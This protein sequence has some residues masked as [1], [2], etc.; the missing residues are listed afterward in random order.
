MNL[1]ILTAILGAIPQGIFIAGADRK[2]I[3]A[4]RALTVLTGYPEG[5]LIGRDCR[6]LHGHAT[7]AEQASHLD[8]AME[9][10]VAWAGELIN[11]TRAG[12]AFW[13]DLTMVPLCDDAGAITHHIGIHR[14][15]SERRAQTEE[16][17]RQERLYAYVFEHI[18]AGI[19]LHKADT[20]IMYANAMASTLLGVSKDQILGIVDTDPRWGFIGEDGDRLPV[21]AYPVNVAMRT[22][23]LVT[24]LLLGL[25]RTT[26]DKLVW[27]M[28][29]A[30]PSLNASGEPVEVVVSFTDVTELKVAEQALKKSEERLSLVLRGAN[31]AAWDWD[32]INNELY[33][34]P[35]WW[36]MIGYAEGEIGADSHLWRTLTHPDD[37]AAVAATFDPALANGAASYEVEFRL[38]HKQ[39]H[40]VTVLSRGFI[41]RD[42]AGKAI[43]VSGTN[44][45]LT[46]QKNA[47]RRIYE[48]AFFDPLTE[49][50]NRRLLNQLLDK[51]LQNSV[52][53]RQQGALL[54]IDLD[55]FKVLNDT[56]GHETGDMLLQQVGERLREA[57][58][59][60]D[61][62]ARLGGDEFLVILENMG[63]TAQ[64]CAVNARHQACKLQARLRQPY[65][66]GEIDYV[67]SASI[68]IAVFDGDGNSC[69]NILKQAD[70]AMYRAKS[71]GRDTLRF[72]D[73]SMQVAADERLNL[74][75][76]LRSYLRDELF[77]L[78]YQP[79]IDAGGSI[80]GAEVLARWFHAQ[81]GPISPVVF[82]P[83][84]ESSGIILALGEWI[85]ERACTQLCHWAARAGT[86]GL[87]LSVNVS[88]RQFTAPDFVA[89][90]L[91]IVNRSG[92]DPRRL[93]LEVTESLL[94]E[95]IDSIIGKMKLLRAAGITFSLDDFG[96]GY[97]S[98]SY[99]QHMPLDEIKIDRS[100]VA[101]L[102][103]L[104]SSSTITRAII[105]MA[106]NLGVDIIAEGVET[107]QQHALL[108]AFGCQRYQGYLFGK[109][110][111]ADQFEALLDHQP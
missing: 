109:P 37:V 44:T 77:D 54:F 53:S 55:N 5:E 107:P 26:D 13:N 46:E 43:R 49:L 27:L 100:F 73:Q 85:L 20:E 111:P 12:R 1:S 72:F 84:A 4:N 105:A 110:M 106:H 36:Q 63:T 92:A 65:R 69:E 17:L 75:H 83:I 29:N 39:G 14:D 95:D 88:V 62:V 86:A 96:T 45:D 90:T 97:S 71:A 61:S 34:S 56:L 58:R 30:S 74:E 7:N 99:L 101:G 89:N 35:R 82:I 108:E 31:D 68:G 79:Q 33:Y 104:E 3:Y 15:V 47:E 57:V 11:Y 102:S 81:R 25:R 52:R 66:C 2:I 18:Q 24:N 64:A 21:E 60:S 59:G 94:A 93:R 23:A 51:A 9:R 40:Y 38:R 87:T 19:V 10:G 70:L 8:Q 103:Q 48:L 41:S 80:I 50:P 78:H 6:F 42:C 91:A 67:S 32:L 16:R 28:C 98:L 22:R 76:D